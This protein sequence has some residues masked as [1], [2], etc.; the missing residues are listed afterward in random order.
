MT[1]KKNEKDK[2]DYQA[3][4]YSNV[5]PICPELGTLPMAEI[6]QLA[7]SACADALIAKIDTSH[8]QSECEDDCPNVLE[9]AMTLS[10]RKPRPPLLEQAF[11]SLR[12][13]L[14][15]R[16]KKDPLSTEYTSA[17]QQL[18]QQITQYYQQL[19][20]QV[21]RKKLP[22]SCLKDF[23]AAILCAIQPAQENWRQAM[24]ARHNSAN[25]LQL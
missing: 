12:E 19:E 13:L 11:S 1:H 21:E 16:A 14:I 7:S 3:I 9:E 4:D 23:E 24:A 25:G 20:S 22:A 8:F 18:G 5:P 17:I 15:I 6:N 10:S 2:I